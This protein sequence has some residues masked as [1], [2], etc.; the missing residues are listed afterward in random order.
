MKPFY[1]LFLVC[2]MMGPMAH[3]ASTIT[4]RSY[5]PDLNGDGTE[6]DDILGD[7]AAGDF[8]GANSFITSGMLAALLGGANLSISAT[9]QI[10]VETSI[11]W[12]SSFGLSLSADLISFDAGVTA[13]GQGG[14]IIDS[15]ETIIS[16]SRINAPWIV[17]TSAVLTLRIDPIGETFKSGD[18]YSIFSS[19]SI[20]A[21]SPVINLPALQSGLQ[22]DTSGLFTEGSIRVIPEPS[23]LVLTMLASG[24]MLIRR[25]R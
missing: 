24:V 8:A 16:N 10:D 15:M 2:T 7:L 25:K 14:V 23:S 13:S 17:L 9:N 18:S 22:W 3:G 19:A 5:S 20:S 4:I 6:G 1:A 11:S 21:L 12:N